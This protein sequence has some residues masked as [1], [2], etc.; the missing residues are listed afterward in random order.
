MEVR[1]VVRS[2]GRRWRIGLLNGPNMPNLGHR[3]Q[4]VYGTISSME[5]LVKYFGDVCDALGVE[6]AAQV[7][8]NYEGDILT[9]IHAEG[10]QLDGIVANPA[11][12]TAFGEATRHALAEAGCPFVEVHFANLARTGLQ[13]RFT[14]TAAGL[15]F[16]L[17]EHSYAAGLLALVATLDDDAVA[18]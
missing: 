6:L 5:A 13:S 1:E 18:G 9:W 15:C 8:S 4:A 2:T 14:A 12:L 17:R 16:G 3:D 10:P 7:C 11:G